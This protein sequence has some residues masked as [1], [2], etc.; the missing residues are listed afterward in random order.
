MNIFLSL[1]AKILMGI[2]HEGHFNVAVFNNGRQ[3]SMKNNILRHLVLVAAGTGFTPMPKLLQHFVAF[4]NNTASKQNRKIPS[5]ATMLFF[6]KTLKDII[7]EELSIKMFS[8]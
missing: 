7:W 8:R 2:C 6:N 3:K 5:S 4:I 1:G